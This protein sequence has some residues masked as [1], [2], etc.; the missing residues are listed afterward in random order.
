MHEKPRTERGM[1]LQE[2]NTVMLATSFIN[3]FI[4]IVGPKTPKFPAEEVIYINV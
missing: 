4:T 3:P 1:S 2:V